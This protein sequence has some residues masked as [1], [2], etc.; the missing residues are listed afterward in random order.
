MLASTEHVLAGRFDMIQILATPPIPNFLKP[1]ARLPRRGAELMWLC[2]MLLGRANSLFRVEF[3]LLGRETFP[4]RL[5]R[6]L[7]CNRLNLLANL[8]PKLTRQAGFFANSLLISL[9]PGNWAPAK[10]RPL[11]RCRVVP[12]LTSSPGTAV[13]VWLAR[14]ITWTAGTSPATTGQRWPDLS[15]PLPP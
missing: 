7:R 1:L 3:S 14:A 12:R 5:R 6:E 4:V 8:V 13:F 15:P 2:I 11:R 10:S 9:L